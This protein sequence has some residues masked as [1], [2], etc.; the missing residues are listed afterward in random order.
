MPSDPDEHLWF[1]KDARKRVEHRRRIKPLRPVSRLNRGVFL[2]LILGGAAV[3][4]LV[5]QGGFRMSSLTWDVLGLLM[6]AVSV[7]YIIKAKFLR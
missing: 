4:K 2:P 3:L 6:F 1:D 5:I 7:G